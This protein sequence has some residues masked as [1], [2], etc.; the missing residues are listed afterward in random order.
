[1]Y[2]WVLNGS[3]II[4]GGGCLKPEEIAGVQI[5]TYQ[6]VPACEKVAEEL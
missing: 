1:M 6:E 4:I 2:Y 3:T 5:K